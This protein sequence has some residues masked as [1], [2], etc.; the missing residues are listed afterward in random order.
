MKKLQKLRLKSALTEEEMK[1]IRGR[2][3][4]ACGYKG[5]RERPGY[6]PTET[7]IKCGISQSEVLGMQN[8]FPSGRFWWCCDSCESTSYC[9]GKMQSPGYA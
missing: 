3:S 7:I 4:G 5:E 2:A 9:K 1:N 6:G 8:A